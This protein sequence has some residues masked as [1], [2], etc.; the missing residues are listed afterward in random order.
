MCVRFCTCYCESHIL[1]DFVRVVVNVIANII[2]YL[3]CMSG[4]GVLC[5]FVFVCARVCVC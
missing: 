4:G 2:E 1:C 3:V 5:A